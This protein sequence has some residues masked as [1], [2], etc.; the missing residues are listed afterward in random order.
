MYGKTLSL[1][2]I[3][4]GKERRAGTVK[5]LAGRFHCPVLSCT[6]N[7]AG[8]V[9]DSLLIRRCFALLVSRLLHTIP[10]E[11]ILDREILFPVTGPEARFVVYSDAVLLK[12]RAVE[13]ENASPAGRLLDADVYREDGTQLS[14]TALGFPERACLVCGKA[15]R[16]CIRSKAHSLYEV[17]EKTEAMMTAELESVPSFEKRTLFS[18]R[19]SDEAVSALLREVRLTPKP[20][21]VDQA[22]SGSHRDMDL[23]LMEKS[24][25]SLRPYFET[26]VMIGIETA[27]LKSKEVFPLLKM[28]GMEAEQTMFRETGGVNTHKGA[29]YLFGILLGAAG[30]LYGKKRFLFDPEPHVKGETLLEILETAN[31]I[32]ENAAREDLEQI[33]ALPEALLRNSYKDIPDSNTGAGLIPVLRERTGLTSGEIIYLLYGLSGV[34]G[35][36]LEGFPSVRKA[37]SPVLNGVV[38]PAL[39]LSDDSLIRVLLGFIAEGKDTNMITRGGFERAKKA[40]ETVRPLLKNKSLDRA[41][42]EQL[43]RGFIDENLSPGG[44]A[45]LLA[46]TVFLA[47]LL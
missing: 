31:S 46:V 19:I 32:A 35:E 26:A 43:D 30:R 23:V 3:L 34:R 5:E 38:T 45:D 40:A 12:R 25:R 6:M 16:N 29:V 1:K 44:S 13:I 33:P 28:A 24:A 15:G 20:G 4:E 41:A 37:L 39:F 9:K 36:V 14:R 11:D 18:T 10:E 17:L 2:E 21:L 8:A 27:A 7:V 42:V 22:N 47:G